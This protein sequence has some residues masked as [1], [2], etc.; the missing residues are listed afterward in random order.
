MGRA[1]N[2][3]QEWLVRLLLYPAAIALIALWW[4]QHQ[5]AADDGAR[6]VAVATHPAAHE[7]VKPVAL[8]GQTS[9]GRRVT[10]ETRLGRLGWLEVPVRLT[11]SP[12]VGDVWA[13]YHQQSADRPGDVV[14]VRRLRLR[15]HGLVTRWPS[16]W[17]GSSDLDLEAVAA[18]GTFTGS[19]RVGARLTTARGRR[20]RCDSGHVIFTLGDGVAG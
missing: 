1:P 8:W 6:P 11:C 13:T 19:V 5:A 4:H 3:R 2:R 18:G 7:W 16:G 10:G 14:S 9:Q 12:R 15:H 20:L 17:H